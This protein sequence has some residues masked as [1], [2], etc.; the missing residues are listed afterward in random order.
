MSVKVDTSNTELHILVD[1]F[2]G[3]LK[4][5]HSVI[6]ITG[7]DVCKLGRTGKTGQTPIESVVDRYAVAL[8]GRGSDLVIDDIIIHPRTSSKKLGFNY[9]NEIR[10]M[11]RNYNQNGRITFSANVGEF[12]KENSNHESLINYSRKK[13]LAHLLDITKEYFGLSPQYDMRKSFDYRWKQDEDIE[14]IV[15]KIAQYNTCLYAAYTSRGKTRIAIETAARM[16]TS[17]GLVLVT[18]PI[19]DTKQGFKDDIEQHHFGKDRNRKITY[20]DSND[21][22]KTTVENIIGRVHQ[23]ELIFVVITVQ[24]LRWNERSVDVDTSVLRQKYQSLNGVVDFWVRDERHSQYN[25]AITSNKLELLRAKSYMDLT[26]TPYNC[27]YKY[28]LNQMVVRNLAWGL[29]HREFTLLPE[30]SIDAISVSIG[31]VS[32][33]I[34][35]LFTVEEGFDPRKLFARDNGEFVLEQEIITIME[36]FYTSTLSRS[37]NPLSISNDTWLSSVAKRCGM[38]VLPSG[39]SG[40]SASAYIPALAEILN[41][42]VSKVFWIDSYTLEK[43]CPVGTSIGDYVESLLVIHQRMVILTCDKFTTGTNIPSLG[44]IVLL[45][46]MGSIS[47]FEQLLGRAIRI[48]E[49][50]DRVKLYSIAPGTELKVILGH[51]QLMSEKMCANTQVNLLDCVPLSEYDGAKWKTYEATDI[52]AAVQEWFRNTTKRYVSGNE[53]HKSLLGCDLSGFIDKKFSSFISSAPKTMLSDNNGSK[54]KNRR[55]YNRS[56]DNGSVDYTIFQK[57]VETIQ[58]IALEMHTR[59]YIMDNY[60]LMDVLDSRYITEKFGEDIMIEVKK[61]I[62]DRPSLYQILQKYLDDKEYSYK[63]VPFS[64]AHDMVFSNT[65]NKQKDGVVYMPYDFAKKMIDTISTMPTPEITEQP[66]IKNPAKAVIVKRNTQKNYLPIVNNKF[67]LIS[68]WF[69]NLKM[70]L[71]SF[72]L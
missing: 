71:L 35:K 50:K 4:E 3:F 68:N 47:E 12:Q 36:K 29:T 2:D 42:T 31:S 40:D 11:I 23:G 5:N 15:S 1:D 8:S 32:D 17:G 14:E 25:A 45:D 39:S 67:N 62:V 57:V 9:D 51:M 44:H 53:I 30:L 19:S 10:C 56:T 61:V 7:G 41:K 59:A 63:N 52:L 46:K 37:K 66:T 60:K 6:Y 48:Y 28:D 21:F 20:M 72:T 58:S 34:A 16:I 18:T 49:G 70:G 54:V 43:N 26:A 24:D 64:E 33:K 55:N 69:K 38:V 22:K 13:N 65:K 27:V